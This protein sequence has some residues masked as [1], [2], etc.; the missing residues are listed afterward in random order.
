RK[1][2]GNYIDVAKKV[3]RSISNPFTID[4]ITILANDKTF[5]KHRDILRGKID[6]SVILSEAK[7]NVYYQIRTNLGKPMRN[8]HN[9][10]K[11]SMI[12]SYINPTY[13]GDRHH[14]VLDIA[15]GRGGELMKF[16][17]AK[18][19]MYVGI[20]ID[21]NG[22]ISPTDGAISRYNQLRKTHPNFPR[23]F[24][25]NADGGAIL[26]YDEQVRALGTM[27]MANEKLMK[28]FFSLNA[29]DR[30]MFDRLNCQFAIHYF[31]AN[32]IIWDNFIKNVNMYLKPGGFMLISTFDAEKLMELLA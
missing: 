25:V 11:S 3:W 15:C 20:D 6:H 30:T 26:D 14:T 1:K 21:N 2:Y 17:Y 4:D 28:Q 32:D 31:L 12:F 23:M 5:N 13:E 19:D 27:S 24:F 22:L 8:F 29:N 9:W 7:E 18:V 10:I 16:Y